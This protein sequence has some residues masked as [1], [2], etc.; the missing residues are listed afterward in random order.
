MISVDLLGCVSK[1]LSRTPT[2]MGGLERDTDTLNAA[3]RKETQC[4]KQFIH[5]A[6][7]QDTQYK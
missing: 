1:L 7:V 2:I 3:I 6:I 4:R 5:R